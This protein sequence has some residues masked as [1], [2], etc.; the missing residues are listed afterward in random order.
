MKK[1][2]PLN[3]T[4][5]KLQLQDDMQLRSVSFIVANLLFFIPSQIHHTTCITWPKNWTHLQRLLEFDE[6]KKA[7]AF[8]LKDFPYQG[9]VSCPLEE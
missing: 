5:A 3:S 4:Y 6:G 8:L 7:I 2:Y 1:E 9:E